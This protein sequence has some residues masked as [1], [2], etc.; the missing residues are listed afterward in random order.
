MIVSVVVPCYNV[1][2][3]IEECM[4]SIFKQKYQHLQVI[5]V[6]NCSTDNTLDI[7]R[8]LASK[9]PIH[10]LNE[11]II[12]AQSARNKGLS[13]AFGEY[14]QFLDADDL[15]LPDKILNQVRIIKN[16]KERPD[17]ILGNYF[18]VSESSGERYQSIVKKDDL[19]L[20]L[21]EAKIGTTSSNLWRR[22][23]LL[24]AG[25]WDVAIHSSQD[26]YL[27]FQMLKRKC[28][29]AI[30]EQFDTIKRQRIAN[31][32][33]KNHEAENWERFLKLRIDIINYLKREKQDYYCKNKIYFMQPVFQAVKSIYKFNPDRSLKLYNQYFK[34]T[35]LLTNEWVSWKYKIAHDLFGYSKA[36]IIKYCLYK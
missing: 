30:S 33:S 18:Q 26:T 7:L 5:C 24:K 11:N 28:T 12:S 21:A 17:V 22:A 19:W 16:S 2:D 14:V 31:S 13:D 6:D 29:F 15:I 20:G 34:G 32:I 23:T 3:Y 4:E 1:Q 27:I 8:K 36:Q 35:T 9:W 10:I 25:G